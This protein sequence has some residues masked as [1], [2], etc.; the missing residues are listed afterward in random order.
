MGD[1]HA[2]TQI[3]VDGTRGV[4]PALVKLK[5]EGFPHLRV[6]LSIGGGSGSKDFPS[7]ATDSSKRK[8]F[9]ETARQ[10]VDDFELDGVDGM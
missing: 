8:K 7:I 3:A 2:D 1:L 4:L 10:I 5:K 9:C 6:L